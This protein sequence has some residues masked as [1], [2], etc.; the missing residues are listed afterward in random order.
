MERETVAPLARQLN[1]FS[2]DIPLSVAVGVENGHPAATV[3]PIQGAKPRSTRD[4]ADPVGRFTVK[5]QEHRRWHQLLE[6]SSV[7]R[8]VHNDIFQLELVEKSVQKRQLRGKSVTS[9]DQIALA[10]LG[11]L[12]ELA[13]DVERQRQGACD[14]ED[15]ATIAF[16]DG[17]ERI[18][19]DLEEQFAAAGV[20]WDKLLLKLY[21]LSAPKSDSVTLALFSEHRDHLTKLAA[22]YKEVAMRQK[23]LVEAVRYV[24]PGSEDPP[25]PTASP[26][27]MP[28][29]QTKTPKAKSAPEM[30]AAE[31]KAKLRQNARRTKRKADPADTAEVKVPELAWVQHRLYRM[32]QSPPAEVLWR[33]PIPFDRS[34]A[35]CGPGTVGM[36]IALAGPGA[37]VRFGGE[38]G[39]QIIDDPETSDSANPNVLVV[40]TTESLSVY[41]PPDAVVRKGAIKNEQPRRTFNF[42]K[43]QVYDAHVDRTWTNLRGDWADRLEPVIAANMR[44]RLVRL[45][46]E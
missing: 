11:R 21:G 45:V 9:Q 37:H 7:V 40:V 1:R 33:I 32:T 34:F 23:L 10:K 30:L 43:D 46:V 5:V 26:P 35:E 22:A 14:I 42:G 17:G 16:H 31:Q 24:L 44:M 28:K 12:R 4:P 20:E 38:A 3:K 39:L 41:K 29:P 18:G 36:G 19:D 8:D 13:A 2:G 25:T 27:V 6:T 15:S